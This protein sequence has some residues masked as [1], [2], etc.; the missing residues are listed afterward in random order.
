MLML[1]RF[2]WVSVFTVSLLTL[3]GCGAGVSVS[4]N[5]PAMGNGSIAG[6]VH[7]GQQP[8]GGST[9]TLMVPG[10][11]GYG[12][13]P[14]VLAT[15]TS[16]SGGGFTLPAYTCPA[17][18]GDVYL[19]ASGGDSGSGSNATLMEAA[20]LGPCSSLGP[21]T[22]IRMSEVT[23]VAAAYALAPFATVTAT[24]TG[25]GAPLSNQQGLTN[26]F[27]AANNLAP[28]TSGTAQAAGAIAG[29]VLPQAEMNTLA[30]I[31]AGCVNSTGATTSTAACGMLFAA[32]TPA[33]GVAPVNTFQAALDIAL[34]P[35]NNVTN[36]FN[37]STANAPFQPVLATAPNDLAVGIEYTGGG[38]TGS[39]GTDGMAIDTLGNAW[40]VTGNTANVHSLTEIS[41]AGLYISGTTGYGANVLNAPQGIAID[42]G[43]NVYVTDVG[44]NKVFRFAPNGS[45]L[46][47]LAPASL[48]VPL[49]IV[50][51]TDNTVWVADQGNAKVTH[52]TTAGTEAVGSPFFASSTPF[53][54]A[55]NA[56]GN[57]TADFNSGAGNNGFLTNIAGS[58][59][60]IL[61]AQLAVTGHAQ[62]VALD[63]TGYAWYTT[64]ASGG[65]TLGRENPTGGS[66]FSPVAVPSQ[67][68]GLEVFVDGLNTVW[69]NTQSR[70]SGTAPGAVL[71]YSSAGAL[72]SPATGYQANGAVVPSGDVPE[73][74]AVD[75][76]GNLWVSGYVLDGNFNAVPNAFVTELIGIAGPTVTPIATAAK[77]GLLGMR[78]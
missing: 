77:N 44:V 14:T 43:N 4:S 8:V 45:L 17:N 51:D 31:L 47:T 62:G 37:L 34:N 40:I 19:L 35:G 75:G 67:Y 11:A 55:L 59:G 33:G 54:I 27:A 57:W 60:L 58:G 39:Y 53:D 71:R 5:N 32:A 72:L 69:L 74:L 68:A 13:A 56:A 24:S 52:M 78:P 41:P 65:A 42:A 3:G 49:G 76:S 70:V 16:T 12:S 61:D 25:I 9:I 66:N 6:S 2:S 20:L 28:F 15:T 23:T 30:N 10:T 22:F 73:G 21:A 1:S 7:G 29:L 36:L 26:A 50:I 64:V 46:A 48:S 18:S 63:R 38:I